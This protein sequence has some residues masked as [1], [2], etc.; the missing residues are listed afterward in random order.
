ML[1]RSLD[2]HR[3]VRHWVRNVAQQA[4]FSFWLPTSTD[5]FYPDFVCE[6]TDGRVFVVEYKGAFL[7]NADTAEKQRIGDLWARTSA[8]KCLFLMAYQERGGV[9]VA[10][11]INIA[12]EGTMAK[13][14]GGSGS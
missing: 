10:G 3:Q 7:D 6:L 1:F 5:Y 14:V 12:I 2:E 13:T 11:Q 9:D 4:E 8:G